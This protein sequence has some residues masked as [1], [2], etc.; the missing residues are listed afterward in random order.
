MA[1]VEVAWSLQTL[2]ILYQNMSGFVVTLFY[3]AE[4]TVAQ[5]FF[6]KYDIFQRDQH[7]VL[8]DFSSH[9]GRKGS[10]RCMTHFPPSPTQKK[11]KKEKEVAHSCERPLETIMYR[12]QTNRNYITAKEVS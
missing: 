8:T 12:D 9:R 5:L 2:V 3:V 10:S 6:A 11:E 7:V 1:V 4:F